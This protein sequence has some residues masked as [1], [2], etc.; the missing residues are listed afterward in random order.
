M[1]WNITAVGKPSEIAEKVKTAF[2]QQSPRHPVHEA[3]ET[4]VAHAFAGAPD[5]VD[6]GPNL[7]TRTV[8]VE[9]SGHIDNAGG[10]QFKLE[11]RTIYGYEAKP[12]ETAQ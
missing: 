9:S 5:T 7:S 3:I 12:V 6:Y 1:S 2:A 4:S 11:A 8:L 10:G